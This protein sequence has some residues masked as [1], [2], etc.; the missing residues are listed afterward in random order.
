MP[1]TAEFAF[2]AS[3][4][5]KI[6]TQKY[7]FGGKGNFISQGLLMSL[8]DFPNLFEYDEKLIEIEEELDL[9]KQKF[10]NNNLYNFL[11]KQKT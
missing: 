11:R 3:K 8:N 2:L 7:T 4:H 10:N 9:L 6:K 5:Y 1:E